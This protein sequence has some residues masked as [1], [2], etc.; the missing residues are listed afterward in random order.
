M[1]CTLRFFSS[2]C[3]LFHNAN[4]FGSCIIHILYRGCAEIK[5]NNSCANGLIYRLPV[6]THETPVHFI[7]PDMSLYVSLVYMGAS[8]SKPVGYALWF[9]NEDS[10]RV[11]L[12]LLTAGS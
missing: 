9:V 1:P 2:K 11:L 4:S 8:G 6:I 3:S 10:F 5:K 12:A 7:Y